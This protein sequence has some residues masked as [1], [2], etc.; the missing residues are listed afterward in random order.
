[1][2][3]GMEGRGGNLIVRHPGLLSGVRICDLSGQLAGAGS[4]RYLAACGA[5]VIR[6]EDPV[7]RGLWDILRKTGPY[8]SEAHG[9]EDGTAFNNHNVCKRGI[10]I[11][12]RTDIGKDLLWKL[13][14]HS[15][16]VTE[17]FS[18]GVM[19]RLGFSYAAMRERN[20]RTIYVSNSGYGHTGPYAP[21]RSWGPIA[22]ALGGLSFSSGLPEMEPAGFGYSYMDH[23]AGYFM[24]IGVLAALVER[25]KTGEGR[26]ID[27]STMECAA[28]LNGPS[29]LDYTVNGVPSRRSG[30][31]NSN[32]SHDPAMVPHGVFQTAGED[33]WIAIACRSDSEWE[34]LAKL[35]QCKEQWGDLASRQRDIAEIESFVNSWTVSQDAD[36]LAATLLESGIPA[37][38]VARPYD[39]IEKGKL[40]SEWNLWPWVEHPRIG[41]IRVEGLPLHFSH[42]D[43]RIDEPAPLLGEDNDEVLHDV[44]GL[45]DQEVTELRRSETI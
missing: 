36:D 26:W 24:A 12:L 19:E 38:K 14:D 1:M 3:D 35:S 33:N 22:Q 4:T 39:R 44:I 34:C 31:P 40:P 5:D 21:Y 15:D 42:D 16:V 2:P 23:M 17:N 13:I 7:R 20:K 45:S 25:D 6:V 11:D 28:A 32:R 29:V 41:K 9:I 30:Q 10:T 18:G 27:L 43:W 37:A 8:V